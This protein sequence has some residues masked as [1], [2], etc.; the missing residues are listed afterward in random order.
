LQLFLTEGALQ[1]LVV[2]LYKFC[3]DSCWGD[4]IYIWLD[5]LLC[6]VPDCAVLVV[7]SHCDRFGDNRGEVDAALHHLRDAIDEYMKDKRLEWDCAAA[8]VQTNPNNNL[9]HSSPTAPSLRI[10]G[11][12]EASGCSTDDLSRLRDKICSLAERGQAAGGKRLFPSVGQTI[13]KSWARVW[14]VMEALL[15][16]ADPFV[17]AQMIGRPV[18]HAQ[19]FETREF[20][21]WE[22]A[23]ETWKAVVSGLKLT[24]EIGGSSEDEGKVLEAALKMR[25]IGGTML[26]TC[27]LVH[28]NPSWINVLLRALLDH[29]L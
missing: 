12:V 5:A 14:A 10:C 11:V 13:P 3:R 29:D 24:E 4:A 19:G 6:R 27:G 8:T 2:D 17:A 1:L 9:N 7:A 21:T 28:L 22:H 16:G 25:E 15:E 26:V 20:V 18:V 23:L